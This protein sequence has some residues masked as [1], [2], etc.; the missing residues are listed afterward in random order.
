MHTCPVCAYQQLTD[1]P[2][3]YAICPCC[4]VEFDY[5]DATKSHAQ[6]RA[7]WIAAGLKWFSRATP[8][9]QGWDGRR[10]LA[11]GGFVEESL[12]A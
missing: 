4:G 10:Q 6:L 1:P 2:S 12:T 7:E 3:D 5:D 8:P 11:Q 9:P